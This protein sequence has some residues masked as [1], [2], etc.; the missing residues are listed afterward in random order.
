[1]AGGAIFSGGVIRRQ[2]IY[3]KNHAVHGRHLFSAHLPPV[4][5]RKCSEIGVR[6]P[7]PS[8]IRRLLESGS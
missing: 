3:Q 5:L 6:V 2:S 1:M 4:H 7:R 8:Y